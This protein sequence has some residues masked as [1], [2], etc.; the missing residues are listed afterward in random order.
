MTISDAAAWFADQL[1]GLP[2]GSQT[3]AAYSLAIEALGKWEEYLDI[4]ADYAAAAKKSA[5]LSALYETV[6]SPEP[7]AELTLCCPRCGSYVKRTYRHCTNCGQR[8]R[9]EV[10]RIRK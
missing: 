4:E 7:N 10:Y 9:K 5:E 1:A 6:R 3:A 2:A 8:L